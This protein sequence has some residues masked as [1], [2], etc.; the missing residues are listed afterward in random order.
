MTETMSDSNEWLAWLD[1]A[2]QQAR[3]RI[4]FLYEEGLESSNQKQRANSSSPHPTMNTHDLAGSP[5]LESRNTDQPGDS[6]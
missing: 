6:L 1:N 4:A 2:A 5:E 3:E